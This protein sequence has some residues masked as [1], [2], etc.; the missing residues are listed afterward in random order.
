MSLTKTLILCHGRNHKKQLPWYVNKD[1]V[2]VDWKNS[3]YIDWNENS[4]PDIVLNLARTNS[5][6]IDAEA[7]IDML[8]PIYCPA[9][10]YGTWKYPNPKF[11]R[12][13]STLLRIGGVLVASIAESGVMTETE[14]STVNPLKPD[15]KKLLCKRI[16]VFAKTVEDMTGGKLC[17]SKALENKLLSQDGNDDPTTIVFVRREGSSRARPPTLNRNAMRRPV[18]VKSNS[19]RT[20]TSRVQKSNS[21]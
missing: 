4:S 10:V 20:S 14:T 2:S 3:V 12:A 16:S 8:M 9:Y 6:I 7:S 19:S 18:V 13:A 17:R 15:Y 5:G 21:I 1:S 11:F